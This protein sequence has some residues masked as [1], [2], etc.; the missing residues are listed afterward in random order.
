MGSTSRND[1]SGLQMFS[2]VTGCSFMIFPLIRRQVAA[3]FQNLVG[4]GNLAQV[5]KIAPRRRATSESSSSPRC[6]PSQPH[7]P[8]AARMS[9]G[10]WVAPLHNQAQVHNTES[11]VSSSS[12]NSFTRRRDFDSRRQ[13]FG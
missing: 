12:V 9:L 8:P 2:P 7:S 3:F 4:H 1:F 13:L 10:V 11:A 6:G 5:V